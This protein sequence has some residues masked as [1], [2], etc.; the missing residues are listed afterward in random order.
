MHDPRSLPA[1]QVAAERE[2]YEQVGYLRCQVDEARAR[3]DELERTKVD[4]AARRI[5]MQRQVAVLE[6]EVALRRQELA[7]RLGLWCSLD[8]I[9]QRT[10]A[11][12]IIK[13][14][15]A[16]RSSTTY[17]LAAGMLR[18]VNVVRG[19]VTLRW[20]RGAKS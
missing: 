14:I 9:D 2:L 16:V 12:D 1:D 5:E 18:I 4:L 6:E 3:L 20:L 19:F 10:G 15:D 13:K 7:E 11:T 17:R 8:D